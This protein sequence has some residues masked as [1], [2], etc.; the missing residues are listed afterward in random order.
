TADSRLRVAPRPRP[1][2]YARGRDRRPGRGRAQLRRLPVP[3]LGAP[4][5]LRRPCLPP[6]PPATGRRLARRAAPPAPPAHTHT[7]PPRPRP[8]DSAPLPRCAEQV[9]A[10]IRKID[11]VVAV[12]DGIVVS[13][14]TITFRVD[15]QRTARF[16]LTATDINE[17]LTIALS[18]DVV[19]NVIEHGRSV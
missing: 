16:G 18:G 8:E 3:P 13:G 1:R 7:S 6:R 9:A 12:F 11:G 4:P 2:A 10:A 15:P 19:S 14:P 17:A 5:P